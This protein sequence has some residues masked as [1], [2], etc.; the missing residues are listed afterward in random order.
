MKITSSLPLLLLFTLLILNPPTTIHAQGLAS[1]VDSILLQKYHPEEPGAS[2]LI[3][4]DGNILYKKAFGLSNLEL[5]VPMKPDDVFEIGSMTKQFTAVAILMLMES[6]KISL[7]DKLTQFIPDYPEGDHIT[8]HHLLTHTSGIR[9]FTRVK[10]LNEISRADLSP[11]EFIDFF[12]NEPKDFQP[13]DYFKYSNAGYVLLGYII[14]IVSGETYAD[15]IEKH[16]FLKLNM[17]NSWYARHKKVIANRASGYHKKDD[18]YSNSNYIS[19]SLPYAA[20]SLMSTVSD[21][22]QWV[23]AIRN[24][25][26]ISE[27]TTEMAFTN[28]SLNNGTLINYGY[29]WHIENL[30]DQKSYEHGGSIFGFKSMG[31]YLPDSEIYVIGL[32]NCDCNS[33]TKITREIAE[34]ASKY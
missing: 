12:K 1:R 16:I 9:D 5:N 21:M 10:G 11:E 18:T 17:T 31:V 22:M 24:H 28:Y 7:D 19:F 32:T 8:I 13:G 14:E 3:A 33:P 20:G 2:F 6:G 26:L 4:K 29:G 30:A 15:Y 25:R 34:L 23:E 27:K